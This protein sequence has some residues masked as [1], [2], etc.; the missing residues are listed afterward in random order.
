MSLHYHTV[1]RS[2]TPLPTIPGVG[3]NQIGALKQWQSKHTVVKTRAAVR[4]DKTT[5]ESKERL[6][7]ERKGRSW[8]EPWRGSGETDWRSRMDVTGLMAV[9]LSWTV[10]AEQLGPRGLQVTGWTLCHIRLVTLD[11]LLSGGGAAALQPPLCQ[12]AD[13]GDNRKIKGRQ[14]S[15]SSKM[16]LKYSPESSSKHG[17][18]RERCAFTPTTLH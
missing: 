13:F 5:S 4:P 10:A 15:S 1:L 9:S 6:R 18:L 8:R 3:K 14:K 11:L 16:N 2:I 12:R 7:S 17:D